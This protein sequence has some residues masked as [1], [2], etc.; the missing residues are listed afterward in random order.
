[1]N[2]LLTTNETAEILGISPIAVANLLRDKKLPG[3]KKRGDDGIDRW[4]I[5][6]ED[7]ALYCAG[8]AI[9][10]YAPAQSQN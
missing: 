9:F 8:L 2:A 5:R 10:K 6:R 7:V 3:I 4:F 1:M